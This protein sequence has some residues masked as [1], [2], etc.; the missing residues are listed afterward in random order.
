MK[1]RKRSFSPLGL[2]YPIQLDQS[3]FKRRKHSNKFIGIVRN[4]ASAF[5]R[6]TI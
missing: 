2:E 6:L 1:K 5:E 4:R 3:L